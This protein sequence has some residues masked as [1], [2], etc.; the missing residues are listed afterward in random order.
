[1]VERRHRITQGPLHPGEAVQSPKEPFGRLGRAGAPG[2]PDRPQD[3][4]PLGSQA[5]PE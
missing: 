3:L 1:M 2:T 4:G 5:I